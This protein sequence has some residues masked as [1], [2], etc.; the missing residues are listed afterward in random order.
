[1]ARIFSLLFSLMAL[2][3][4]GDQLPVP[5]EISTQEVMQGYEGAFFKMFATLIALLLGIFG[6]VWA[7]KKLSQGR[8]SASN[9][10]RSIKVLERRALS[11]KTVLYLIEADGKKA[12]IAESQLEIK[13]LIELGTGEPESESEH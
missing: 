9:N 4:F 7:L 13:R 2:S 8:L 11:H 1:M 10:S 5:Q 6:A 12:L 3:L